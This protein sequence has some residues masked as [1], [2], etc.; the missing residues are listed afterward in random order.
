MSF[1]LGWFKGAWGYIAAAGAALVAILV[2]MGKAKKAGRDEA[3]A[4]ALKKQ[5]ENVAK[6]KEAEN[7][8]SAADADARRKRL[9]DDWT[10][11]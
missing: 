1:L 7:E 3:V 4:G 5:S 8:V 6:A 11:G 10:I 2:A 9:R